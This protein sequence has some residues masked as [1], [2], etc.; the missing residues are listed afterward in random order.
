MNNPPSTPPVDTVGSF[1]Q[2]LT[3]EPFLAD[4]QSRRRPEL[5]QKSIDQLFD[6]RPDVWGHS[7]HSNLRE[8]LRHIADEHADELADVIAQDLARDIGRPPGAESE[9]QTGRAR[10]FDA[11]S[12]KAAAG[13]AEE[14]EAYGPFK[15]IVLYCAVKIQRRLQG[16]HANRL[17]E[18]RNRRLILP[19]HTTATRLEGSDETLLPDVTLC[20]EPVG[21]V[22]APQAHNHYCF[23]GIIVECKKL[24]TGF[25]PGLKQLSTYT[26]EM[27]RNQL[28]RK[29]AI[30]MVLY[31]TFAKV[32][33]FGLDAVWA[34]TGANL[35][36]P[37]GRRTFIRQL[38]DWSTCPVYRLGLDTN[39][40]RLAPPPVAAA[41]PPVA[42]APPLEE[43]APPP[44]IV[45]RVDIGNFKLYS[46]ECRLIADTLTGQRRRYILLWRNIAMA[47]P[48]SHLLV[49][50]WPFSAMTSRY[51]TRDEAGLL[52]RIRANF[53]N[54]DDLRDAVPRVIIGE[55]VRQRHGRHN[56]VDDDTLT[57]YGPLTSFEVMGVQGWLDGHFRAH[58]RIL[59]EYPG[60]AVSEAD[61][62]QTAAL[63]IARAMVIVLALYT[64]M[65]ILHRGIDANNITYLMVGGRL[66][67]KLLGF[68]N[69]IDMAIADERQLRPEIAV[70][71]ALASINSLENRG[72]PTPL[73]D[74]ESLVNLGSWL[75]I[76]GIN[77]AER[78]AY[79]AGL[80]KN[81]H[82][83]I[84]DWN[85][86]TTA[87]IAGRKRDHL[88]TLEA[89]D[90][91]ILLYMR[92]NSPLRPLVENMYIAL[93]LH[94]GCYGVTLLTDN[95]IARIEDGNIRAALLAIPVINGTRNPLIL[96]HAVLVALI[97]NILGSL[98]QH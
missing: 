44:L 58:K 98:P 90:T 55:R 37:A 97:A 40:H 75:G 2:L 84:M 81:P 15:D 27:F 28:D 80:P 72:A 19:F 45:Y 16:Q 71:P 54:N 7:R 48:P 86:G 11:W 68:N 91:K 49:D 35:A 18:A 67:I 96:R 95:S 65:N 30:G 83:P 56:F 9:L 29:D 87:D 62:E 57:S 51:D 89:F 34:S 94:P 42:A 26:L 10:R 32:V 64:R 61:N 23:A 73:D 41:P 31:G 82:L 20:F 17:A 21:T 25:Q 24:P 4:K 3:S 14:K 76:F 63:A 60:E 85:R 52:R 47:G 53:A 1:N 5:E 78:A 93:F 38:V 13:N 77:K 50:D 59:I 12:H 36:T 74:P 39:I 66:Q 79:I 92:E 33:V 8:D 69:S 6:D 70:S 22:V 88:A 46:H 43:A